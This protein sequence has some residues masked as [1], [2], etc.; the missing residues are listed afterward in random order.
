[1]SARV[2]QLLSAASADPPD[3]ELL[4]RFVATRD[5]SAFAELVRRHGPAVLRVCRRLAGPASAD[6][7]FQAAFLVL[8][9]RAKAVRKAGS[10]GS[11]LIGVAG[12]VARQMR[13]SARRQETGDSRAPL[14]TDSV[15]PLSPDSCL[16][17]DELAAVLDD[18]LTRLP[19]GLRGPVVLCYLHGR[20]HEQAAAELGGSV[21]TL[22]RR[23][24]RAKAVLRARLERRGVVTAVAA[25]LVAG[26]G[27]AAAVP[28][29]LVRKSVEGVFEFL[30]GGGAHSPAAAVAKG[31]VGNMVKPKA[32]LLMVA[33]AAALTGLGVVWA[34]A[35]VPPPIPT[36]PAAPG[37]PLPP[38]GVAGATPPAIDPTQPPPL[39]VRAVS[40][41]TANFVVYAASPVVARAVAAE[42]EYQRA[43]IA[44][45]LLGSELPAWPALCEVRVV[46]DDANRG[47]ATVMEYGTDGAGKPTVKVDRMELRGSLLAVLTDL[48]PHEVTHTVLA[49]FIKKQLPRWADEGI[50]LLAESEGEQ[51]A[52]DARCR[53]LLNAGRGIRLRTLFRMTEYPA[54]VVALYAQGHSVVR[55]LNGRMPRS[56]IDAP[57]QP[58]GLGEIKFWGLREGVLEFVRIGMDG[59]TAETWDKAAKQVYGFDS[60]DELEEWW[61][62]SLRTPPTRPLSKPP[63]P[64]KPDLIPPAD[65]PGVKPQVRRPA[66]DAVAVSSRQIA[67][68][69][70]FGPGRRALVDRLELYVSQ[71][72]GKTWDE[73]V[74]AGPDRDK[75]V[76]TTPRDGVYWLQ[77]V[78]VGKNGREPQDLTREPPAMK[79]IVDTTPPTVRVT[80]AKRDGNT[81][82]VEW[83]VE[84]ANPGPVEV[85]ARRPGEDA[86]GWVR[87][88][89]PEQ[90]ATA[91]N[92]DPGHTGPVEVQVRAKDAA[93]N[94]GTSAVVR[95]E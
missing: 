78:T 1:M 82:R 65:L 45:R 73:A 30:A 61:L 8:A 93:G 71:D 49:S 51:A 55:F 24:D 4:G 35:Q 53:E 88:A 95:A 15:C 59:N 44:K 66:A 12:R 7:A 92:F 94:E 9:C 38:P 56:V 76:Y 19:D 74:V 52:H 79:V 13:R 77:L 32:S 20:T 41:R 21:R 57:G 62:K 72:E 39:P 16:L 63:A 90:W 68:P 58:H 67:I 29:E 86:N 87:R 83:A 48:T 10:V 46:L 34:D 14:P 33:A 64:A 22:R 3:A 85:W 81:V 6:D 70:E 60:V 2:L 36:A 17:A 37:Q 31:V 23:L 80:A 5:E 54:D 18:E 91:A 69:V 43:E 75:L 89:T 11:W 40:H 47:S 26:V 42:A 28:P 84:D 25:G 27:P 50:A